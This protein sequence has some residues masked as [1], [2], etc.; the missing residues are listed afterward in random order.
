VRAHPSP[1]LPPSGHGPPP[2]WQ[3]ARGRARQPPPP[4]P[5]V[6]PPRGARAA[7]G[8][9]D[10]RPLTPVV[11]VPPAASARPRAAAGQRGAGWRA[12][13]PGGRRLGT[14]TVPAAE[15]GGRCQGRVFLASVVAG[16]GGVLGCASAVAGSFS[17]RLDRD[18]KLAFS[19]VQMVCLVYLVC[20]IWGGIITSDTFVLIR[21]KN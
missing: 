4:Q 16:P 14:G 3:P 6:P 13:L 19:C 21:L 11:G 15:K 5:T 12:A 18:L 20:W 10:R 8:L 1:S 9:Q 2:P 7:P 17:L